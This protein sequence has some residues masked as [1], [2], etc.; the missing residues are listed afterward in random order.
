M[1]R[2]FAHE[3]NIPHERVGKLVVAT[4]E[5]EEEA[6]KSLV[7]RG[8]ANGV[9]GLEIISPDAVQRMEPNVTGASPNT[10]KRGNGAIRDGLHF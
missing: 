7:E 2:E 8:E 3:N 6:M 4:Q 9:E 5:G 10:P 1:M